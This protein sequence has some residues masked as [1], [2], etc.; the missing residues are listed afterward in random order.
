MAGANWLLIKTTAV[1]LL[2][3]VMINGE[4]VEYTTICKYMSI[5]M[6]YVCTC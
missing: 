1:I 5:C 4:Y 6:W 2:Y 3:C